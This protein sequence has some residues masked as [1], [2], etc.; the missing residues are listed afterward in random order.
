MRRTGAQIVW[1]MLTR[2]GVEVVFGIPG[3]AIMHTYHP[4]QEYCIRHVLVRHEQCAAH[5]ADGYARASGRVGVAMATSGPGATNLVTGIATAMMDSSPIVCI[6]GQVPTPVIGSDAFQE[7]DITGITLPITKHN[8]LVTD[9]NDLAYVIHEAFYIARSGRPGPVLIDLPKDV[10]QAETDFGPPEEEVW[11]PGYRPDSLSDP[12]AVRRAA[13]LINDAQRPV[14]L[15]G[16][17][18]LMSGAMETLRAFVE[19][20]ET[21]VALT[22]L[23]KG[24]FPESHPLAL[25]M[26]GMHG[27]A[28]TNHAIQEADLLLAFGMRFDDRV[29]GKLEHYAPK[30]RKIHVDLDAVELNKIV[31]V[32]VAIRGDLRQV[33]A[34]LLPLV[35][36]ASHPEWLAQISRWQVESQMRDILSR[37][38]NGR[39]AAPHFVNAVWE[40]TQGEAI[41]VTDVGQHQMWAAQ[42]YHTDQPCPLI[43]SGGLGTMGFG[44]PAAIGVQ[45]A[46]PGKEVWA[47][48]GD[49]GFQMTIHDLAT[50]VQEQLPIRIALSNNGCLG[51][52][53]QWQEMFYDRRYE[54]TCLLNPDFVKLVKSYG[55][56]GWRA[57]NLEEARQSIAEARAH[58]GPAFIEFQIVQEG[59]E[60]NVY[61]MVPSGS[62][63]HEMIRR[64]TLAVAPTARLKEG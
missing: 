25:G 50:V 52:V 6:T 33:L 21:P 3:G 41:V 31:P 46:R 18:I 2:E 24:G 35:E 1:E 42:Y 61:P 48:V 57:T 12:E 55:I 4:R 36:P 49:G 44:L 38:Q 30:A 51:M 45:I 62:A 28:F 27:E 22:L 47:I 29:T 15:A 20:T 14:I 5:A 17:G 60:G 16:H 54:S 58:P 11:L 56:R 26:M 63:L 8:Y 39:L 32:D 37:P 7:M 40:A 34:Q 10:Q 53:R 9:V 64:P 59:E 19:K 43:T 13:E 23:G